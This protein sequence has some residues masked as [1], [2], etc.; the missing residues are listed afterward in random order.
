MHILFLAN[1][2]YPTGEAQYI[3]HLA[4][5]LPKSKIDVSVIFAS[6]GHPG[7]QGTVGLIEEN[8]VSELSFR[9][10]KETWANDVVAYIKD[11]GVDVV[12]VG[13]LK[14]SQADPKTG[15]MAT[16]SAED[17]CSAAGVKSVFMAY[18]L[19]KLTF[20]NLD[21]TNFDAYGSVSDL[22]ARFITGSSPTII[23]T[24]VRGC[25]VKPKAMDIDI[26]GYWGIA[27]E[28]TVLGYMGEFADAFGTDAIFEAAKQLGTRIFA[29][30]WGNELA[31]LEA[32]RDVVTLLPMIPTHRK[33]WYDAMDVFVYP[34][35]SG[36]FPFYAME[37]VMTGTPIVITPTADTFALFGNET[38][39]FCSF[40]KTSSLVDGIKK[41]RDMDMKPAQKIAA[42]ELSL[43][44]MVAGLIKLC[45]L[46]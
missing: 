32:Y 18:D 23:P 19:D 31:E 11:A 16:H 40:N 22:L 42:N 1:S 28:D 36:A 24:V 34:V 45:Q 29:C 14:F 25:A 38:M 21:E 2:A 44:K 8:V 35:Y 39:A 5:N 4:Q 10:Y 20:K 9:A 46:V 26:R 30:G 15:I 12:V 13:Q 33:E 37:A 3:T 6:E 41:A 27:K 17:I 7:I 43:D